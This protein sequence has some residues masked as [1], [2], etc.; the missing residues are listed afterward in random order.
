MQYQL[1][2]VVCEVAP[3]CG[4]DERI[5]DNVISVTDFVSAQNL[6]ILQAVSE[7]FESSHPIRGLGSHHPSNSVARTRCMKRQAVLKASQNNYQ[8]GTQVSGHVNARSN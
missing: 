7:K 4:P 1:V 3:M 8:R 6:R 5:N 2:I